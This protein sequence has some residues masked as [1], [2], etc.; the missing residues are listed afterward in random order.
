LVIFVAAALTEQTRHLIDAATLAQMSSHAWI[1]N[2]ARG[3]IIDTA[4]LVNALEQ[5]TIAGAA[6]D[7][8]DPEPLPR[9]HR[10]W[11]LDNAII[12]P[13][14][15]NTPEMGLGLLTDRIEANVAR[16]L[17]GDPLLGPVDLIARY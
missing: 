4:A 5:G 16:W 17:S 2:L 12:T 8:T 3:P 10:L 1:V 15:G 14:V 13:H 6:L 7:V 9:G 11:S